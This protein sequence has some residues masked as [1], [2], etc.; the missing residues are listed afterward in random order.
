MYLRAS[1]QSPEK[2][3][4]GGGVWKHLSEIQDTESHVTYRTSPNWSWLM[5]P[6]TFL[7]RF[8]LVAQSMHLCE[9]RNF[10]SFTVEDFVPQTVFCGA[11]AT[12]YVN[13]F[14]TDFWAVALKIQL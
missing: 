11:T 9:R 8:L 14:K 3:G 7:V 5:F 1:K 12:T 2:S 10:I 6:V 4:Y 13:I